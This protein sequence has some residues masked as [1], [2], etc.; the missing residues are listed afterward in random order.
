MSAAAIFIFKQQFTK[1]V[2][3][4]KTQWKEGLSKNLFFYWMKGILRQLNLIWN[5]IRCQ[6]TKP[7]QEDLQLQLVCG[8]LSPHG[9][10]YTP[11]LFPLPLP[12]PGC[13]KRSQPRLRQAEAPLL[14]SVKARVVPRPLMVSIWIYC[15][16]TEFVIWLW[17]NKLMHAWG[18]KGLK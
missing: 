10:S 9:L 1:S 15:G 5:R 14:L 3:Q 4:I 2:Q 8:C 12:M 11:A 7:V 18:K 6:W 16:T 17:N 13:K